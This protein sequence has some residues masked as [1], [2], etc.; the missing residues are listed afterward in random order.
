MPV[1][2][3]ANGVFDQVT[4]IQLED[5]H[6]EAGRLPVIGQV[7]ELTQEESM[8]TRTTDPL[9]PILRGHEPTVWPPARA[10]GEVT[11][12]V[13]DYPVGR[14][15]LATWNN[16]TVLT[17][18]YV[19]DDA[20]ENAVVQGLV[21]RVSPRVLRGWRPLDAV[22]R[23]LDGYFTRRSRTIDVPVDLILA[24]PFQRSVL[25]RLATAVPYGTTTSYGQLAVDLGRSHASRAVGAALGANP[26][27]VV[28]PCHRV[29]AAS[30]AL[31]GYA[32]GLTAKR[33]LLALETPPD[34]QQGPAGS[35]LR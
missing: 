24:T 31:T 9:R 4:A 3:H 30:G 13:D 18:R 2:D 23:Q 21:R 29:L 25:T 22:R 35:A 32:G 12:A 1:R 7:D 8:N 26:L 10:G 15:L 6:G 19:V 16:G 33:Y 5:S 28:L 27:C 11:Y 17:S 14:V 20:T 34:L